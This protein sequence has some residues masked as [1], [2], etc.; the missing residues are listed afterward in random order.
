MFSTTAA[1]ANFRASPLASCKPCTYSQCQLTGCGS[2]EPFVCTAGGANNGCAAGSTDWL[3]SI[4]C[5]D[6]CD[7]SDCPSI[8][9]KGSKCEG[10]TAKQC[11]ALAAISS[12]KCGSGAPYVCA[13]GSSQMGCSSI[14]SAWLSMPPT[15]CR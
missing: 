1:P 6:C 10:C 2:T 4:S 12:Q 8:L 15:T 7:S 11:S 5:T 9:K 13:E 14:A 3:N